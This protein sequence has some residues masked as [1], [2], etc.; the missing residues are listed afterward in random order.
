MPLDNEDR[1]YLEKT[2][3]RTVRQVPDIVTMSRDEGYQKHSQYKEADDFV[4]GFATGM[5]YGAFI[6][7]F[8]ARQQRQPTDDEVTEANQVI[9]RRMREIKDA[10]FNCG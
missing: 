7:Y 4:L 1:A 5:I 6:Q 3:D 2:I 8:V 10:I 9:L